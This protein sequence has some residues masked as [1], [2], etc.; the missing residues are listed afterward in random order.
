MNQTHVIEAAGPSK[1]PP[2]RDLGGKRSSLGEA[3]G[4]PKSQRSPEFFAAA[5]QGEGG[6][7]ASERCCSVIAVA[8]LCSTGS[9]LAQLTVSRMVLQNCSTAAAEMIFADSPFLNR[10]VKE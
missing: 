2:G 1:N 4:M 7:I 8:L 5:W 6:C 3:M 9:S 10:F